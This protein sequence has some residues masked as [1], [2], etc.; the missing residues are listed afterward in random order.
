MGRWRTAI[1]NL[2]KRDWAFDGQGLSVV[3]HLSPAQQPVEDQA[4]AFVVVDRPG[5]GWYGAVASAR[6]T[7]S[8]SRAAKL[9]A[10]RNFSGIPRVS[11]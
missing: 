6:V 4:V 8:L 5:M 1:P 10:S 7:G 2:A 9:A 11:L 3:A